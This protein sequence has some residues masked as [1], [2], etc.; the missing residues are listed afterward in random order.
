[1]GWVRLTGYHCLP[2]SGLE[3]RPEEGGAGAKHVG[4]EHISQTPELVTGYPAQLQA[5]GPRGRR[6]AEGLEYTCQLQ[7]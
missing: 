4:L 6:L 7:P 1:M 3:K 5:A 2:G